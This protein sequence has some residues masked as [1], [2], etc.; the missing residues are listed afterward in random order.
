VRNQDDELNYRLRKQGGRIWLTTRMRSHYQNRQG[1]KTLARQ[2]FQYGLWKI[3]VLQKHPRQ[4]SARHFV[5]PLLVLSLMVSGLLAPWMAAAAWGCAAVSAAYALALAAATASV[6]RRHGWQHFPLVM[7]A[8]AAMHVSWG[9]GFLAGL[10]RFGH[11]WFTDEPA[12][13]QL[14]SPALAARELIGVSAGN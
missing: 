9:A 3:R 10:L 6:A 1:L 11:R 2:F 14:R 7:T 4:M 8:F 12:P 13:P 5:P